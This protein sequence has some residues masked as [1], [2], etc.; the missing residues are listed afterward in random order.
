MDK[1]KKDKKVAGSAAKTHYCR[2]SNNDEVHT[3]VQARGDI[4]K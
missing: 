3:S 4:L 2:Y 1:K